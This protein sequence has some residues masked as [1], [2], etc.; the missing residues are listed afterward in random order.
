M[1][2]CDGSGPRFETRTVYERDYA[3]ENRLKKENERLQS[4]I[5][6]IAPKPPSSPDWLEH[7]GNETVVV[8]DGL[9]IPPYQISFFEEKDSDIEVPSEKFQNWLNYRLEEFAESLMEDVDETIDAFGEA[10]TG[11][12]DAAVHDWRRDY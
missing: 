10:L 12:I 4:I 9:T 7:R 2:S 11:A 3:E 8:D 6:N 1:P 5:D